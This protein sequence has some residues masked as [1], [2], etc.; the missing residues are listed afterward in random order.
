MDLGADLLNGGR[1]RGLRRDCVPV[2]SSEGRAGYDRSD[3]QR[4]VKKSPP[5]PFETGPF[6]RRNQ[7][8]AAGNARLPVERPDVDCLK[9]L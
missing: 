3:P 7:V 5:W 8:G 2:G 9:P 6:Y 4:R 1:G